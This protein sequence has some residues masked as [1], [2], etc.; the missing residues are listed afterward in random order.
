V[1]KKLLE[2][3]VLERTQFEAYFAA[4]SGPLTYL[5]VMALRLR[6]DWPMKPAEMTGGYK[7][8]IIALA[9]AFAALYIALY[10]GFP[11]LMEL[12]VAV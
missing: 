8:L 2:L 11:L 6:T 9:A 1:R 4:L 12:F 3:V 7:A 5:G 10:V